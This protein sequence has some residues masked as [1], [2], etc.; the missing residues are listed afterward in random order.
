MHWLQEKITSVYQWCKYQTIYFFFIRI[1]KSVIQIQAE[2]WEWII[3][4]TSWPN[5]TPG[6]WSIHWQPSLKTSS[7]SGGTAYS[8]IYSTKVCTP[9]PSCFPLYFNGQ[10]RLYVFYIWIVIW[11]RVHCLFL[12]TLIQVEKFPTENIKYIHVAG[13]FSS[14]LFFFSHDLWSLF[15]CTALWK[16]ACDYLMEIRSPS[17]RKKPA[18]LRKSSIYDDT[19]LSG[20][21]K[22]D[23]IVRNLKKKIYQWLYMYV[24]FKCLQGSYLFFFF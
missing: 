8:S 24:C 9:L 21:Q 13:N 19:P 14:H 22:C 7:T 4:F 17:P 23:L 16:H 3:Q 10:H 11:N 15:F 5:S 6:P 1:L 2:V 18:F 20:R 12:L